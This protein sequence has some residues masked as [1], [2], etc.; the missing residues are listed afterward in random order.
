MGIWVGIIAGHLKHEKSRHHQHHGGP[1]APGVP[2]E[3]VAAF[4]SGTHI[5]GHVCSSEMIITELTIK[6]QCMFMQ[7]AC[8][9]SYRQQCHHVALLKPAFVRHCPIRW[10]Q[11]VHI[12][13]K[14]KTKGEMI[15]SGHVWPRHINA[16]AFTASLRVPVVLFFALLVL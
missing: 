7:N 3:C 1:M 12:W 8:F 16:F 4:D 13:G 14:I 9:V 5:Q 6:Q 2:T 15:M 11:A 10:S